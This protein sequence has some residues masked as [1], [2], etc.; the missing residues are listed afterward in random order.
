MQTLEQ[1]RRGAMP[2]LERVTDRALAQGGLPRGYPEAADLPT[3]E[4]GAGL[5][6][7]QRAQLHRGFR[8]IDVFLRQPFEYAAVHAQRLGQAGDARIAA[9]LLTGAVPA[10]AIELAR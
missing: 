4:A 6:P 1:Q 8:K 10:A 9:A 2:E 7:H 5:Q 3:D